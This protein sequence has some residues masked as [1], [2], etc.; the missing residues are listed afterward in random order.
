MGKHRAPR[1]SDVSLRLAVVST[2]ALITALVATD[3]DGPS[4]PTPNRDHNA[5]GQSTGPFT[6]PPVNTP[7]AIPDP[8][9]HEPDIGS[10]ESPA[11]PDAGS[12]GADTTRRSDPAPPARGAD[13]PVHRDI[14][15]AAAAA[16]ISGTKQ[17]FQWLAEMERDL[18]D[19]IV[20]TGSQRS[21]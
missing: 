1:K 8:T 16:W 15:G 10:D 18:V 19:H 20:A 3:Q 11:A 2:A 14:V 4:G 12:R 13:A 17:G 9:D 21:T 5:L 6:S 7:E